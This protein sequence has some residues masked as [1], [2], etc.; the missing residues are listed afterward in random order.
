[1]SDGENENDRISVE[2]ADHRS[3]SVAALLASLDGE[4]TRR[5]GRVRG[6]EMLALEFAEAGSAFFVA[7][8]GGR[9]VGCGGLCPFE[10][11][12]GEVRRL[13]VVPGTRG[14]TAARAILGEI[15][16]EARRLG[17]RALRIETGKG[18][19]ESPAFYEGEGFRPIPCEAQAADPSRLC[20]EKRLDSP[21]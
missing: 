2:R 4:L 9:E 6:A 5:H 15:E 21:P 3:P 16:A 7:R 18:R 19:P 13:Y 10:P 17:Y 14:T 11:G 1:M 8:L 12:V 20:F